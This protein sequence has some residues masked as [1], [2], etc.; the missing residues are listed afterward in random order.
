[1][2]DHVTVSQ[3]DVNMDLE[4]A[5]AKPADR[6]NKDLKRQKT[7]KAAKIENKRVR[8]PRN[9]M[10]FAKHPKKAGRVKKR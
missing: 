3:A 8:K 10:T 2:A 5:A 6:S 4:T 1:M 7:S 9:R